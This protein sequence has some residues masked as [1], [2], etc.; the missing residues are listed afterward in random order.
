MYV[1]SSKKYIRIFVNITPVIGTT[2]VQNNSHS[3]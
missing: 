2:K 1:I 3:K